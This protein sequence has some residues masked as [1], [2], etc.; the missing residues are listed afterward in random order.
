VAALG[1]DGEAAG[2]A[3]VF[4]GCWVELEDRLVRRR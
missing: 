2:E 1:G 4:G 3:D